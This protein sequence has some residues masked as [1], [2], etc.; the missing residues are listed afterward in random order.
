MNNCNLTLLVMD[1]VI[2]KQGMAQNIWIYQVY[3]QQT[4]PQ[5][6]IRKAVIKKLSPLTLSRVCKFVHVILCLFGHLFSRKH[7]VIL[8]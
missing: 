1:F 5:L 4:F 3:S 8:L 2:A 6:K 7:G